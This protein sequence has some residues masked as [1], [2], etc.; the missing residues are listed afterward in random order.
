MM[1]KGMVSFDEFKEL[2]ELVPGEP[3]FEICFVEKPCEYIIVKYDDC[4]TFQR[5]GIKDG[6]GE[7]EYG[8]LEDL[9]LADLIDGIQLGRD[10][11]DV[12]SVVVNSSWNLCLPE[13]VKHL[14]STYLSS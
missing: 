8:S 3:E 9:C 12:E 4:V 10:W 14:R 13:D 1:G 5:C 7:I 6:S 11:Q 2:F